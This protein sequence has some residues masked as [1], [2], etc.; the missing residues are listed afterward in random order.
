[1]LRNIGS[2]FHSLVAATALILAQTRRRPRVV[3]MDTGQQ[4]IRIQELHVRRGG[5]L[6]LPGIS[7][8]V[9]PGIVTGLL[10]PS[11]SGK[12]TL[13]RAIVGVQIV[14]QGRISVLGEPAGAASLRRRVA[15]VTQA[16][17]VYEDLT[18]RENLHYFA[19]I[20][21]APRERVADI[22]TRVGLTA[23]LEQTVRTFSG[24]ER[25]RASLA[26]ALLGRPELLI[27]DEPTVDVD[28]ILRRELWQMFYALANE[29][30]TVLVSSHVMDEAGRC[31][32]LV[33]I[34]SGRIVATGTPDE[35]L[36]RTGAGALEEAFVTL[37]EPS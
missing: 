24:G 4:A 9:R 27:L 11:G 26:V 35:L 13:M 12:T 2:K 36:M 28:P 8:E 23:Q 31:Q 15:Y 21:G 25:S 34:R 17:S 7:L 29:G 30:A 33:F 32:Q 18:L 3:G 20:V 1:M 14:E 5:K 22:A 16:P 10:G 19:R 6:I 37:A